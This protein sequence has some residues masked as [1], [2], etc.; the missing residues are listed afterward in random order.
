MYISIETCLYLPV[1]QQFEI[2]FFSN[3][4]MIQSKL[5]NRLETSKAAKLVYYYRMLRGSEDIVW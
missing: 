5:R 3:F 4:G 2:F 1:Q